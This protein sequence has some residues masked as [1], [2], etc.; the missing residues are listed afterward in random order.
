MNVRLS[1]PVVKI[2]AIAFS[3]MLLVGSFLD[4]VS[5]SISVVTPRTTYI[6]TPV[7]IMAAAFTHLWLRKRPFTIT[8]NDGNVEEYSGLNLKIIAALFGVIILLWIPRFIT[9]DSQ[10]QAANLPLLNPGEKEETSG[11]SLDVWLLEEKKAIEEMF[12]DGSDEVNRTVSYKADTKDGDTNIRPQLPYLN[13]P[14][15]TIWYLGDPMYEGFFHLAF[16]TLDFKMVNNSKETIFA[17][18]VILQIES[19]G[20]DT[21]PLIVVGASPD[22]FGKFSLWNDGWGA[23]KNLNVKFRIQENGET[24]NFQEPFPNVRN[25]LE[26][27]KS[28]TI[29]VIEEL[30]G[31]GVDIETISRLYEK[32]MRLYEEGEEL[33]PEEEKEVHFAQGDYGGETIYED[34]LK[35]SEIQSELFAAGIITFT[36]NTYDNKEKPVSTRFIASIPIS[37]PIGLGDGEEPTMSYDVLLDLNKNNYEIVIPISHSLKAGEVDRFLIRLGALKSSVHRLRAKVVFNNNKEVV[38]DP[39]NISLFIPRSGAESLAKT[40][41]PQVRL[42]SDHSLE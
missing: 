10:S 14:I 2:I 37:I 32:Q 27:D 26:F 35:D 33:S 42:P 4:A 25:I 1:H 9:T 6:L 17:T 15:E 39:I 8:K 7:M 24:P 31:K 22:V 3:G 16:P 40:K 12:G 23:V 18:K 5:N 34:E 38:S 41:K 29:S 28:V 20:L 11:V 30:K 19:S 21:F 36:G 13:E